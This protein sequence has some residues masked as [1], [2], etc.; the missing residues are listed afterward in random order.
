MLG[1]GTNVPFGIQ[2]CTDGFMMKGVKSKLGRGVSGF[3]TGKLER[4]DDFVECMKV[5]WKRSAP[6]N[7][8]FAVFSWTLSFVD[9]LN[10]LSGLVYINFQFMK[11]YQTVDI[12]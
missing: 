10:T 2:I 3:D 11:Y 4:P 5:A 6:Y 7:R 9:I 8:G 12:H 1:H